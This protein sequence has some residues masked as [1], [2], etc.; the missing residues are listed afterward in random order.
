MLSLYEGFRDIIR[1]N[2]LFWACS[3]SLPEGYRASQALREN[4]YPF[5][6]LIVLKNNRM[7]IV[8]R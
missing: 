7:T 4:T 1:E 5:L 3:V 8:A 2:M 6:A